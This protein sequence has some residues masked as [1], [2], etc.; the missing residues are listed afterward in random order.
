MLMRHV[1]GV[2]DYIIF[3]KL[4]DAVFMP[5]DQGPKSMLIY[6]YIYIFL[7]CESCSQEL[8]LHH[9]WLRLPFVMWDSAS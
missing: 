6:I 2:L 9:C 7:V 3:M 5:G 4:D 1:V 8:V